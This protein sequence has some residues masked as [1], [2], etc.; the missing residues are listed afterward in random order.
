MNVSA[1]KK[2]SK[3]TRVVVAMSGGVDSAVA[4]VLLA[5][6]GHEVIGVTMRL[7]STQDGAA[8]KL[9]KS[10]CSIEDVDDARSVCRAIGARHYFLN[11]ER[12]FRQHVIDYFVSEY[13]KGRTPYPCLA[14]NDRLKFDFLLRRARLLKADYIATG[15]HARL[16]RHNGRVRLCKG[17]DRAKDQS[18][19]LYTLSPA[20]MHRL[21]LPVGDYTKDEVREIARSRNLSVADKPDSQDI[22]F[23]PDGDYRSFLSP[24]IRDRRPGLVVGPDGKVLREHDGIHNF[25]IGQRKGLGAPGGTGR[26]LYV[27]SIEPDTGTVTVGPAEALRRGV[28][29]ASAVNWLSGESPRSPFRADARIRYKSQDEPAW[30]TPVEGGARIEFDRPQRAVT[31]GQ[32]VVFYAGDEVLGGGTIELVESAL[33]SEAAVATAV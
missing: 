21:L 3:G 2:A 14:C 33:R 9:N 30:I 11:F 23:I 4:A 20:Q 15:H 19:V 18:Y 1:T 32:A 31:P 24:R 10:C 29:F 8:A 25:T 13:S 27:T 28:L 5:E 17:A 6:S 7:F 16:V 26:P 22:C 12:E